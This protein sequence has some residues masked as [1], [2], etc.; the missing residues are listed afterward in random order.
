MF[1]AGAFRGRKK[2]PLEGKQGCS[3]H[4]HGKKRVGEESLEMTLA[5]PMVSDTAYLKG[6][7][8]VASTYTTRCQWTT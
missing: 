6:S 4:K 8:S 3:T 7:A 1:C 2:L 5:P